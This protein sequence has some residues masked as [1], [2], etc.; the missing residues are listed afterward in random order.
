MPPKKG[1]EVVVKKDG[2][3]YEAKLYLH[4]TW[5]PQQKD[6]KLLNSTSQ[7]ELK[8][9][10]KMIAEDK[11]N[12]NA[13]ITWQD[14]YTPLHYAVQEGNLKLAELLL[15]Q[16]ADPNLQDV[17]MKFTALHMACRLGY[18]EIVE[19]LIKKGVNPNVEDTEGNNASYWAQE[20]GHPAILKVQGM[21]EVKVMT[22]EE[23]FEKM[24]Q[25][26]ESRNPTPV[27]DPDGGK[28]K[29]KK[30]KK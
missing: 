6:I 29:G 18:L 24:K 7:G 9:V 17:R 4:S 8:L 27:E 28:K 3:V 25:L 26:R 30:K 22:V 19:L 5:S 23:R 21:P 12:V 14:G 11:A 16:G 15:E 2:P 20:L 1:E 10:K 13:Q